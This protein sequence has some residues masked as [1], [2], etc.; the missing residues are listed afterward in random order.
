MKFQPHLKVKNALDGWASGIKY[1]KKAYSTI[2][3]EDLDQA[4]QLV[5]RIG[6]EFE[7][8][9]DVENFQVFLG[10]LGPV[11]Q[12][13]AQDEDYR[14]CLASS[15]ELWRSLRADLQGLEGSLNELNKEN[16]FW[17]VRTL[18]GLM[19]LMRNLSASSQQLPRDLLLQNCSIRAFLQISRAN[20][21]LDEMVHSFYTITVSFL[22]N[23]SKDVIIFDKQ[24]VDRLMDFLQYPT[25]VEST[26][27]EELLHCHASF[28]LNL[29]GNTDFLYDFFRSPTCDKI[30]FEHLLQ[31]VVSHHTELFNYADRAE[32]EDHEISPMD[33]V[34]LKTFSRFA[35]NESFINYLLTVESEGGESFIQ[36]MKLLQLVVTSSERWDKFEL[37]SIM[38]WCFPIFKKAAESTA[39]YFEVGVDDEQEA[40]ILHNKLSTT[41]DIMSKLTQYEQ[42]QQ[43]LLSYEGLEASISL[44]GLLQKNLVRI[45]FYKNPNGSIKGMKTMDATGEKVSD[46]ALLNQRV[47]YDSFQILP[48]NFPECKLLI[49][50]ILTMLVYNRR[51]V[52]DRIRELHGL[53]LVLSNCVID[54]NDPFIKERSVVCIKYL[55][56]DNRPNQDFVAQ[57]EAKKAVQDDVLSEAGYEVKIGNTGELKLDSVPSQKREFE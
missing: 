38:A 26:M 50:E 54:D 42:V 47:D 32:D 5:R 29:S 39:S 11:V 30:I 35:V 24:E 17:Y 45:N 9:A 3:R 34:I 53:E 44:L 56:Q 25:Q 40:K 41:L 7:S 27:N 43:Y 33:A 37:T 20:F 6:K 51:E 21:E 8:C 46:E 2:M 23:I 36:L 55:L 10:E 13:T 48:T 15:E 1:K 12:R 14:Q 52:Q 57:L 28:L 22:H 19:L 49:I 31:E 4:V 18:R 16:A